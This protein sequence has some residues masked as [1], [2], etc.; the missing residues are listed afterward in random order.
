M[1][2][3]VLMYSTVS[4]TMTKVKVEL[5]IYIPGCTAVSLRRHTESILYPAASKAIITLTASVLDRR[6]LIMSSHLSILFD[7]FHHWKWHP[8]TFFP[9][10]EE[11]EGFDHDSILIRQRY[12]SNIL[13]YHPSINQHGDA[14]MRGVSLIMSMC[15]Q[16]TLI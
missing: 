7:C 11:S 5:Y 14:P 3:V 16:K 6:M 13:C 10:L 1:A 9:N 2:T 12:H 15:R 8:S 4:K